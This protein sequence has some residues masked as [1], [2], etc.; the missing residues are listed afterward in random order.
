MYVP[1]RRRFERIGSASEEVTE[2]ETI[3]DAA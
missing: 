2:E 1:K 3:G